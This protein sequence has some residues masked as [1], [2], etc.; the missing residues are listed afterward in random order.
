MHSVNLLV[1][2]RSPETAEHVNSLLRNSGIKIHVIHTQTSIEVKRSLDHDSPVL[3]LYANPDAGDA[4]LEEI[5]ELAAAFSVPL[6]LFTDLADTERLTTLLAGTA[7][8]V[9]NAER[10][11]LLSQAVERLVRSVENERRHE[12]LSS[13]LEELEHRYD[14]LLASSSDAIAYIHEGLH[15][16]AN[17]TYLEAL[18]I[19]GEDEVTG[20]SLLELFE[21]G[22]TDFKALLKGFAKGSFP[23]EPLAV[24]VKRP[25]GT[26]FSAS[27]L[28]SPARFN[29]ED[30]TQMILQRADAANELAAELERLR[31]TDPLT[32]LHNRKSF[33]EQLERWLTGDGSKGTAGVLYIEPDGFGTL[34]DEMSVE[35]IDALIADLAGVIRGVLDV[36]DVAARVNDRGFAVLAQRTTKAELEA[37]ARD[38]LET[39]RGH[40]VEAGNR[41]L[42][43]SCSIGLSNVGRMV[44]NSSEILA[45]ARKAQAEAA[46]DGDQLV[47]YRPQ[48]AAVT[49]G[50]G[51]SQ[52]SDRIRHALKNKAF[53]SVQQ[54][55]IDLDGDGDALLEHVTFM[56][57]EHGSHAPSDWQDAADQADLG[58]AIDRQAIESLMQALVDSESRQLINLNA[59]SILDYAFPGWLAEQLEANCVDPDRV[60]LQI[61]ASVAQGN[62]RPTQRLIKELRPKGCHFSI[63][64]FDGERR[65]CQLLEH[66]EL[67]YVKLDAALTANL[68]S[69]AKAQESIRKVV[70]VTEPR[71]VMVIA[72]EVSNTSALAVLW[73]CGVK[74]IAGSFMKES[75]QVLAQ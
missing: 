73:Q 33:A 49:S 36:S 42:T 37:L 20:L 8:T 34:Q 68:T 11:E 57:D 54:S 66:L 24:N 55:I 74:L 50:D 21:T 45:R 2:D 17:H 16:Y 25:D 56:N 35:T 28:F 39:C 27:V 75:M 40:I 29:G 23:A 1:T 70:E 65:N 62:L 63:S 5:S 52:W 71:N 38:I 43:I 13:Y 30:C 60:I 9:I 46:Q 12:A 15:V 64:R 19:Q 67:S 4:P 22:E 26:S 32:Q 59:N 44:V 18:H 3:I 51:D 53:Y 69:D 14:L 41:S 58:G 47:V 72:D 61:P 6:A 7:C 10:D 31:L 48:L